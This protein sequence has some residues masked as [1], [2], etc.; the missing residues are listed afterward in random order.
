MADSSY[1][2]LHVESGG[3]TNLRPFIEGLRLLIAALDTLQREG[4][5]VQQALEHVALAS[6]RSGDP[7]QDSP[8]L[9]GAGC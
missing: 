2:P 8:I 1:I 3:L 9:R 6:L 5:T 7:Q 4:M